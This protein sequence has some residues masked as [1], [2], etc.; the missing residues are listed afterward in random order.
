M[1][2]LLLHSEETVSNKISNNQEMITISFTDQTHFFTVIGL[3][4]VQRDRITLIIN[5]GNV[6]SLSGH[7][8]TYLYLKMRFKQLW[9]APS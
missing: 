4:Y 1:H 2:T 9:I 7:N 6:F 8:Q 5:T 3:Q